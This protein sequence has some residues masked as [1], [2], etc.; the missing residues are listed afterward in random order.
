MYRAVLVLIK[1]ADNDVDMLK[2]FNM[3]TISIP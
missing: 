2:D 3:S 1:V